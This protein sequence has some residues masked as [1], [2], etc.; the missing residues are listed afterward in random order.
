MLV[1]GRYG[2]QDFRGNNSVAKNAL[3]ILNLCQRRLDH[4]LETDPD[5]RVDRSSLTSL[6]NEILDQI[7]NGL[8][9]ED[10]EEWADG[11]TER[12]LMRQY[13]GIINAIPEAFESLK[14]SNSLRQRL[15][16]VALSN[17]LKRSVTLS[18]TGIAIAGFGADEVFPSLVH[19]RVGGVIADRL[20]TFQ[21]ELH[22][23]THEKPAILLPLAQTTE[24]TTFLMGI[25][26]TV[27]QL[28]EVWWDQWLES[29]G[30][31]AE[32][33]I[34]QSIPNIPEAD[35][36]TLRETFD[37]YAQNSWG[38]FAQYMNNLHRRLRFAPIEKSAEF[39]SK[40]ELASLAENLVG[41][42]S[43]RARIAIDRAE[44][45]GGETD[46]AVVSHGDGFVWS[47]RKHYFDLE[48]NPTWAYRQASF[49]LPSEL[50]THERS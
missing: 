42:A 29:L 23:V 31:V 15:R 47:K 20:V 26:P 5:I 45:V 2:C 39:L 27:K 18:T 25:D 7:E 33:F 1:T 14:L 19:F 37:D 16:N 49:A 8:A 32:K 30:W 3:D 22:K 21:R 6:V 28:I 46:V 41:L 11:L 44:T 50:T 34:E 10:Y 24:A 48:T 13:R 12:K 36:T 38:E 40:G 4:Q 35:R 9:Q 17:I 43:L